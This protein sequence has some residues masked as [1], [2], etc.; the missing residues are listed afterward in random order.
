MSKLL[1]VF[2]ATGNQGGSVIRAVLADPTL[3]KEFKIRGI[4]RDASKPAAHALAGR[5]VEVKAAD[6]S[7]KTSL[8]EAIKGSHTI[9]L[10]TTPDFMSGQASQELTHGKNVADVAQEAEVQ[11]VIFSSL[12]HVTEATNG[13]LKH[14]LHFDM[15]ADVERYIRSKGLSSTFIL[16]GYFMSNFTALQMLKKGEDGV[17]TLVYPVGDKAEFPLIDTESDIGKYVV[18]AIR[19]RTKVL[20]KQILAAADYYTPTRIISEFEEVTGKKGRFVSVDAKTY[21]SFLPEPMAEEMLENHLFIKNPGYFVGKS[22]KESLDL[23]TEAGLKPTTWKD[24]LE[25]NKG[26]FE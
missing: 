19:S 7:S 25:K 24:F 6:M 5:G 13:R 18:A 15:K 2:G 20:G 12:L 21:K 4:T 3:S 22:L 8:A 10:V 26:V 1:T 17:Y 14:V 9:F 23:L 16:P 11:H